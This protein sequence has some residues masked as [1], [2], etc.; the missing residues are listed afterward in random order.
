MGFVHAE[1][2]RVEYARHTGL[3]RGVH[4]RLFYRPLL[5]AFASLAAPAPRPGLERTATEELLAGLAFADPG[6]AFDRF[7]GVLDPSTRL[8]TVLRAQF[9]VVA[10][11]LALAALPDSALVRFERIV[12][13]LRRRDPAAASHLADRL[14][15]RPEA[16][17]RLAALAA[18]SS[19]FAD[20]LVGGPSLARA[21][22][23]LP[24]VEATLFPGDPRAEL[25]RVAG[26]YGAGDKHVPAAGRAP[27]PGAGAGLPPGVRAG[28]PP[29]PGP[30]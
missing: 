22:L 15:N 10:P 9:P 29:R 19:A 28:P 6:A 27:P 20:V 3:V 2:L 30:G 25:V 14:A 24:S 12:D 11:A 13:A 1:H 21:L 17:R 5:D 23:D 18:V 26:A 7:V 8:G 16:T 4:E